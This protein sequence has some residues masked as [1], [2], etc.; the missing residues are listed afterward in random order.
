MPTF[1]VHIPDDAPY[2]PELEKR[3]A[4]RDVS[5]YIRDVFERGLAAIDAEAMPPA[6]ADPHLLEHL[7]A[8][9]IPSRTAR[10]RRIWDTKTKLSECPPGQPEVVEQMLVAFL[11]ALESDPTA[12]LVDAFDALPA[13]TVSAIVQAATTGDTAALER[14]P[15]VV[16]YTQ[17]EEP[18]RHVAEDQSTTTRTLRTLPHKPP[19][20]KSTGTTP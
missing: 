10:F 1:A 15:N 16:R 3:R 18:A 2:L 12:Q 8:A 11:R 5:S 6:Q 13:A 19:K 4:T 9:L 20:P 14:D 7:I 17:P